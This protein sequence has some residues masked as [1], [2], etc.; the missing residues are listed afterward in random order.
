M[1]ALPQFYRRP[2][3]L[4]PARHGRL[5]LKEGAGC[6]FA[7]EANAVPLLAAEMAAACRHLP[8]VFSNEPLPQ[9]LAVL[10]LRE[11]QNLFVDAQG[12]WQAGVY[13][14]AYVRRYPFIFAQDGA[15]HELTLCID[16]AAPQLVADGSGQPL[17]DAAGQPSATTR[18]ALAFCRDY[19]AQHQLTRAFADALLTADLLVDQRAEASVAAG[20]APL[21]L[22][23]FKVVDEA[24]FKAL[25]TPCSC[26][27]A[28]R[29][30][31]RWCTATCC[32]SAAGRAC[33]RGS[34]RAAE[35]A[36][37][38]GPG[39]FSAPGSWTGSPWCARSW[40]R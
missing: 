31:C 24:R 32:H 16:E 35:P 19:Q 26:T 1:A 36:P 20:G 33:W 9:P 8:I 18:S 13:V 28:P 10:G 7:R 21:A 6:G 17:F 3:V 25:P 29:A 27:G 30:G 12:R 23:G 40:A 34:P 38:A 37:A 22:Q 2:A 5:G 15:R 14:P 39:A 11:R 4:Q